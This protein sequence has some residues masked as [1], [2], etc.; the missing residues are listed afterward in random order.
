MGIPTQLADG[1]GLYF[2]VTEKNKGIW[3]MRGR[4]NGIAKR[5]VLG[6]E[7]MTLAEAR[8]LRD[9]E[10]KALKSGIDTVAQ[11]K[12]QWKKTEEESRTFGMI[13][14]EWLDFWKK[15][16]DDKTIQSTVGRLNKHILP[17]LG[18]RAY[19]GLSFEDLKNVCVSIS[20]A[21]HREMANRVSTIIN[22]I[23]RFAKINAYYRYNLAEDLPTLFPKPKRDANFEGFPAITDKDGVAERLI[24][25]A[26]LYF[27]VENT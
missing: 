26:L 14:G 4:L 11:K 12:E 27:Q 8:A 1:G 15:D 6:H 18:S 2:S 16:K 20:E 25:L 21:G 24:K 17:K 19:C 9:E 23:C 13:A 22:Q 5:R 7:D 3:F 10:R